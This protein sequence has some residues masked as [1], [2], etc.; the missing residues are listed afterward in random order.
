LKVRRYLTV[1][2]PFCYCTS[3]STTSACGG[4]RAPVVVVVQNRSRS[5][6]PSPLHRSGCHNLPTNPRA[7]AHAAPTGYTPVRSEPQN[8]G[9]PY[10]S[11][12]WYCHRRRRLLFLHAPP[13]GVLRLWRLPKKLV[14]LR[15]LTVQ[16][17]LWGWRWRCSRYVVGGRSCHFSGVGR[18]VVV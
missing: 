18:D 17:C 16:V 10:R 5:L 7:R 15:K 14:I 6:V 9:C 12:F 13:D 4:L 3:F 11:L 1:V 2:F 8:F